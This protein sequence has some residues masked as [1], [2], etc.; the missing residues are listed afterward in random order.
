V[1]LALASSGHPH[2]LDFFFL[3]CFLVMIAIISLTLYRRL[4]IQ[5]GPQINSKGRQDAGFGSG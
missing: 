4:L 2:L 1:R 3:C 5:P